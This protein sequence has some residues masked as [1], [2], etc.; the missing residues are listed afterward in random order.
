MNIHSILRSA[1]SAS[2]LDRPADRAADTVDRVV[3]GGTLASALRGS[4]LGHPVHPLLIFLPLGSWMTAVLFDLGFRDR[5]TARRLLGI[6][7]A[8]TP[9]TAWA[10]WADFPLLN[11]EQR[12]VGLLHA[13]V[14]GAGIVLFALAYRAHRKERH[15]RA[16]V[17]TVVGLLVVSI[18]G[19]LGGHLSYA[20]GA[21]VHR[22]QAPHHA[23][24]LVAYARGHAA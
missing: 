4:W 23:G 14:N 17:L 20:Q 21:G 7:L 9:P 3:G 22:F 10:G 11:R 24:D 5:T 19:A 6:G 13:I 18:G 1:E 8:A 15:R 2:A 16:T 12:R